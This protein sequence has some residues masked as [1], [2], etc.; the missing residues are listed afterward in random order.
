MAQKRNIEGQRLH[1]FELS[2]KNRTVR[3]VLIILLLVIGAVSI[4]WALTN[5]LDTPAGWQS[6]QASSGGLSCSHE[7]AL[8][9]DLG[10]GEI[11]ATQ[12]RKELSTLYTQLTQKAWLLFYW[13][14]VQS[15][16]VGISQINSHPN[17]ELQI[18]EGLYRA[19]EQVTQRGN[20]A[21]YMGPL[22]STYDHLFQSEDDTTAQ[23]N[24]PTTDLELQEYVQHM[25]SLTNDPDMVSLELRGDNRVFLKADEMYLQYLQDCG[26]ERILDF[27]W[28]RNAFVI[29]YMA[30]ALQA[31]GFENGYLFS[32][33]G[34]I[35]NL[36]TRGQQFTMNVVMDG[37]VTAVMDYAAPMSIASLRSY[38]TYEELNDRFY[39]YA[40]GRTVTAMVDPSDG[41]SRCATPDLIGYG[42]D[43][44]CAR[45]AME[46]AP[47]Y[48]SDTLAEGALT[49]FAQQG[50]YTLWTA[51]NTLCYTQ[52]DVKLTVAENIA[53]QYIQ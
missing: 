3:W 6:I 23:S 48:V 9:Y 2:D 36:D 44:G 38:P 33:D 29:D 14:A 37:K 47:A 26:V 49:E 13:E 31:A 40:D 39:T 8:Q 35:R 51:D 42:A 15:D 28:L 52:Q 20:R 17:E 12:E 25:V 53:A 10:A 46:L 32:V 5:A 19:L 34:H 16:T 50:I 27:G 21:I 1:H 4:I 41:Q 45:L 43:I 30:D 22:Y 7:F 18:D 11:S 24:D